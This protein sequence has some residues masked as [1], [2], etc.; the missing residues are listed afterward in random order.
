VDYHNCWKHGPQQ[1]E[2]HIAD[3]GQHGDYEEFAVTVIVF[4]TEKNENNC[5]TTKT[6]TL[7]IQ[8]L[9]RPGVGVGAGKSRTGA[10]MFE[11][12]SS[13]DGEQ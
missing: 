13:K 11:H 8:R 9:R 2:H 3:I 5:I 10:A 6:N 1:E 4:A 7:D 12:P